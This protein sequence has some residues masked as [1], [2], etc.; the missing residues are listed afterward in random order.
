MGWGACPA[1]ETATSPDGTKAKCTTISVPIDYQDPSKGFFE[2]LVTALLPADPDAAKNVI[3][4]NRG[5]PGGDMTGFLDYKSYPAPAEFYKNNALIAIQP[6]GLAGSTPLHCD[7]A[8]ACNEYI[9]QHPEYLPSLSTENI[10]RDMDTFRKLAELDKIDYYGASW[11]TELGAKYATLFPDHTDEMVLDSA[12]DPNAP[13]GI[14]SGN[15]VRAFDKRLY[16][17]FDFVAEHDDKYQLGDTPLKVFKAW[18]KAMDAADAETGNTK[19]F[20]DNLGLPS[21]SDPRGHYLPPAA[22]VN[23]LPPFLR[24]LSAVA[25]PVYN[26]VNQAW[27]RVSYVVS[28]ALGTAQLAVALPLLPLITKDA[29]TNYQTVSTA[30]PTTTAT[31]IKN[32]A[33]TNMYNRGKWETYADQVSQMV[34]QGAPDSAFPTESSQVGADENLASSLMGPAVAVN[35]VKAAYSGGIHF[36]HLVPALA[37]LIKAEFHNLTGASTATTTA[38]VQDAIGLFQ[39]FWGYT[40]TPGFTGKTLDTKPLVLQSDDDPATPS[41]GGRE[42]AKAMDADLVTVEGGDHGLFRRH[43]DTVDHAVV[44][45]FDTGKTGLVRSKEAP[46]PSEVKA[47]QTATEQDTTK[48]STQTLTPAATTNLKTTTTSEA[49]TTATTDKTTTTTS[50]TAATTAGKTATS[51]T[52]ATTSKT[53]TAPTTVVGATTAGKTATTSTASAASAGKTATSTTAATTTAGKTAISTTTATTTTTGKTATTSTTAGAT[54]SKAATT[55]TAT[56]S[57]SAT[58]KTSDSKTADSKTSDSSSK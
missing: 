47:A 10:A 23:D 49:T 25:L 40:K 2:L 37:A 16:Q 42:M 19:N 55:S 26:L 38:A 5:G 8:A 3:L 29:N 54:T 12:M 36:E 58:S 22:Q 13:V 52:A 20:F 24:P 41:A 6:R 15:Q 50:T 17:W 34:N 14:A 48:T 11:G 35:N 28:H 27:A 43:N 4:T 33:T 7:T 51:T 21:T 44:E 46:L 39:K 9:A 18:N 57:Q 1:G 30:E 31:N 53:A 32:G 45:Y 56:G